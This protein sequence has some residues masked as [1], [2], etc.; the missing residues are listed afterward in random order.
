V[1]IE[2]FLALVETWG[3]RSERWPAARRAAALALVAADPAAAA[4]LDAA[5][6]LDA[7]L[8]AAPALAPS[9]ALQARIVGDALAPRPRV[10][11]RRWLGAMGAI[12]ALAG[13]CAAGAFTGVAAATRQADPAAS[14]STRDPADEAARF[15]ADPPDLTAGS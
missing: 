5:R 8:A 4:A 12:L 6:R 3:G 13:A 14:T 15:L 9:L 7:V 1:T 2:E 11:P 10:S